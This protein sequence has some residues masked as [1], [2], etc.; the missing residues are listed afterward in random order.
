ME[1]NVGDTDKIVRIA[2]G[3][4]IGLASVGIIANYIKRPEI[5]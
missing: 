5:W 3:A 2:L 1:N 4:L